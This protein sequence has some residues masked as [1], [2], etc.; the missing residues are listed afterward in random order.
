M[1]CATCTGNP[2]TIIISCYSL[3]NAS[4]EADI[5]AFFNELSSLLRRI[6]KYNILIIN[7][8]MI[9]Y[10]GKDENDKFCFYMSPKG[11]REYL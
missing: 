4:D 1:M 8:H 6:P 2:G 7:G 3:T 9:V 5:T 11:N 10:L